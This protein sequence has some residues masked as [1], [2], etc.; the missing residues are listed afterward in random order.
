MQLYVL[1]AGTHQPTKDSERLVKSDL[2][3]HFLP[4][5]AAVFLVDFLAAFFGAAF[6]VVFL[7]VFLAT[8]LAGAFL[9]TIGN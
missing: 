9:A 2:T 7:M 1:G 6:L 3:S 5:L 4:F 8:F